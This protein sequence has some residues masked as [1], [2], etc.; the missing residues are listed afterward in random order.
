[1]SDT[2]HVMSV[3]ADARNIAVYGV[4]RE[5]MAVLDVLP[6]LAPSA[7]VTAVSDSPLPDDLVEE[8]GRRDIVVAHGTPHLV[9]S[10]LDDVEVVVRSPG[11]PT[12]APQLQ[13]AVAAGALVTTGSNLWFA[14]HQPTNVIAITGTKGKS[15]TTALLTHLLAA[16][17]Q[18]VVASGNIGVPLLALDRAPSTYDRV[19]VELS[20]Y[21]L[22]DLDARLPVGVLLNLMAE[23]I[24]W[25]GDHETYR[26]EKARIVGLSEVL[27]ANGADAE[28]MRRAAGHPD[29][30]V[31][32]ARTSL[33]HLG[34]TSLEGS[35][36]DDA[37][38]PSRLVGSH[39]RHN[40][41]GALAAAATVH[42]DVSRL[43]PHVATFQ[44]LPHR[45]ELVRDD[46]RL[47]IDDSISTIPEAAVAA[48]GAFPQRPVS[49]LLGGYE[50]Q[51]DHA[52]LVAALA[53]R[54]DVMVLAMPDTGHRFAAE[55]EGDHRLD[56]ARVADLAEAVS[57][58]ASATPQGGVVLLSPA[59]PSYGAFQNFEHRGRVFRELANRQV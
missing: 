7:I 8:L 56:V 59:A 37:L 35:Q 11:V 45:L 33:V 2:N 38:A 12:R 40:L 26:T 48:L 44:P 55:N 5:G 23:H 4:G 16:D 18:D 22:A 41:A 13:R 50:R 51:Q 19:L 47:W 54:R 58:A 49:L 52:P 6:E 43:L 24:D 25:H 36:L 29:R 21:Q 28:V 31:F 39:Q 1:M 15:T 32:D 34:H 42:P 3:M 17:G 9:A 27:V 46:G 53:E 30:R 10:G 14:M 20:S 57:T